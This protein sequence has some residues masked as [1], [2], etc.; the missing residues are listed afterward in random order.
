MCKGNER[1][2]TGGNTGY[3]RGVPPLVRSVQHKSSTPR[4]QVP[5]RVLHANFNQRCGLLN[6]RIGRRPVP[7][8]KYDALSEVLNRSTVA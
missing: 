2:N 8:D 5:A 6:A 4:T 7:P 3:A 1:G